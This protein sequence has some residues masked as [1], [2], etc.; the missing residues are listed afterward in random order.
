[1]SKN[2]SYDIENLNKIS[3]IIIEQIKYL[4]LNVNDLFTSVNNF[5]NPKRLVLQKSIS[6]AR[7]YIS[8]SLYVENIDCQKIKTKIIEIEENITHN[9]NITT[10]TIASDTITT[11]NCIIKNKLEMRESDI[12]FTQQNDQQEDFVSDYIKYNNEANYITVKNLFN[13]IVRRRLSKKHFFINIHSGMSIPD[14]SW[15]GTAG[16]PDYDSKEE[17]LQ[18]LENYFCYLIRVPDVH[19]HQVTDN[20]GFSLPYSAYHAYAKISGYFTFSYNFPFEYIKLNLRIKNLITENST[21]FER[22]YKTTNVGGGGEN[23]IIYFNE[24]IRLGETKSDQF[25]F[26]LGLESKVEDTSPPVTT[27][28]Q[29][30]EGNI[31]CEYTDGFN[32]PGKFGR[33]QSS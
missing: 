29:T 24:I 2:F 21:I 10:G 11:N 12:S 6:A 33:A 23:F 26:F 1:M 9:G 7:A 17:R 19:R 25:E 13:D 5:I 16:W 32:L 31:Y 14:Y 22:E 27:G 30:L 28:V 20:N 8:D 4:Q 18:A 15:F 3:S